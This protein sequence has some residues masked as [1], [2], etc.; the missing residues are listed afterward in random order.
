MMA[1]KPGDRI[2]APP[3]ASAA[4]S[5][6]TAPAAPAATAWRRIRR[7]STPHGYTVD[8]DA[9]RARRAAPAAEAH[10]D[11]RQPQ[12][13]SASDRGDPRH[14]R[15]GRCAGAV[16][17]RA[18]V[19]HDRRPRLAAAARGRRSCHDHEHLQEPRRPAVWPHRHQ[20]CRRSPSSSTPSPIPASPRISTRPNR[21]R[22]PITLLD[23]K[24]HGRA[25]AAAMA[26]PRHARWPKRWPSA[27]C[28][29]SR[30]AAAS[31][32][33]H[34]FAVEAAAFGGGQAAA[35]RLRQANILACGIGL[36]IAAV[37]GDVNGLRLGTPEIVRWGMTV[38]TCPSSR[39]LSPAACGQRACRAGR[40][41]RH[42]LPAPLRQAALRQ[43]TL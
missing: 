41:R 10:H 31:P 11:R 35:K 18:Y 16:R 21:R 17:C 24:V 39:R 26:R 29:C 5:R 13:V 9:L 23:W 25:Y 2:I 19:G 37:D 42:R 15:R 3:P 6:T 20:R 4:T 38:A 30:P 7:R 33:S 14:R 34:Q 36:P 22:S 27:A 12:P 43:L 1:A 8:V 28:R 32:R 40:C